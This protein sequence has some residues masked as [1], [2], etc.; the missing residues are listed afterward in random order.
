[1]TRAKESNGNGGDGRD[2]L[3]IVVGGALIAY[4]ISRAHASTPAAG[5]TAPAPPG[6]TP[7]IPTPAPAPPGPSAPSASTDH[8]ILMT[9]PPSSSSVAKP[10][11]ISQAERAAIKNYEQLRLT[12]YPDGTGYAI[13]Y[14]HFIVPADA[15]G[16]TITLARAEQLFNADI[17]T[18]E[19]ALNSLV[20]VPLNQSE[21]DALGDFVF[22]E[23]T[24][25]FANS[26]LLQLLNSGDYQGA[27]SRLA[28]YHYAG[29]KSLQNLVDRRRDETILF[30]QG[31]AYG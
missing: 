23:G 18:A 8:I 27:A 6:P 15:I 20:R 14:G 28:L 29:G 10:W 31:M 19:R 4:G 5:T 1:M 9:P 7:P 3:L 11:H 30:Q 25:T 2:A 26:P 24:G 13:G 16:T 17:A 12:K 22:N 21:I